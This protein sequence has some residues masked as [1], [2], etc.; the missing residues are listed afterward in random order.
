ME[1]DHE[2]LIKNMTEGVVEGI[3]NDIELE[4]LNIASSSADIGEI[5][6]RAKHRNKHVFEQKDI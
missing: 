5:M 1:S 2:Q 4:V 3:G 6:E